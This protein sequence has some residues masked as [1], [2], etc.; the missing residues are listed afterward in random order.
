MLRRFKTSA[1]RLTA[2]VRQPRKRRRGSSASG[3]R[4]LQSLQQLMRHADQHDDGALGGEKTRKALR[5]CCGRRS[6][7][8][9]VT[10][11][12]T[13]PHRRTQTIRERPQ[14]PMGLDLKR[15]AAQIRTEDLR[16][17]NA[18]LCQ[19]SYSGLG[20][21]FRWNL[22]CN[23]SSKSRQTNKPDVVQTASAGLAVCNR[24]VNDSGWHQRPGQRQRI[25]LSFALRAI[26]FG[27]HWQRRSPRAVLC[28]RAN[29][30]RWNAAVTA[31]QRSTQWAVR[32]L[33]DGQ[34]VAGYFNSSVFTRTPS[35]FSS[36]ICFA[37][38]SPSGLPP[39]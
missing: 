33:H 32:R 23:K 16:I 6:E 28:G 30:T 22:P 4:I 7:V 2:I 31:S 35:F 27:P 18:S 10:I 29:Q 37:A 17:T 19:L 21:D 34:S 5:T 26:R 14:A 12:V 9:K 38:A 13:S 39:M 24:T 11:L 36:S 25:R 8:R 1:F 15:A 20:V 3:L